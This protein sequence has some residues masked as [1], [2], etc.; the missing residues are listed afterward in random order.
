MY[1]NLVLEPIPF[2]LRLSLNIE[3]VDTLFSGFMLGDFAVL[4]G[5]SVKSILSS[6]CVRAQLPYQLG[7]LETNVLFVDGG[8]SFGLYDISSS[9]QACELNPKEVLEKIYV[10]RAFTAYQ[11]TS[12]VLE[13]LQNAIEKFNSKFVILSNLAQL[14]LDRD[15]PKKEAKEVFLQLTAYLA[16]FAKKNRVIL[17]ATHPSRFWSKSSRFF[18]EVLCARANVVAEIRKFNDR[19]HF[20]LEKHPTFKLGRVEFPSEEVTLVD[21]LEA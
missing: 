7:G 15:I 21:F 9:A 1:Q 17:F 19:P 2:Q 11:L 6:L 16:E 12:L 4:R 14:Y 10:S 8:N 3:S 20:V 13:Q 18:E 5:S